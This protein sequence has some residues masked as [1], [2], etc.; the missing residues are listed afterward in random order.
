MVPNPEGAISNERNNLNQ[1]REKNKTKL[2]TFFQIVSL[3]FILQVWFSHHQILLH[4]PVLP[5]DQ[6]FEFDQN[7]TH[8]R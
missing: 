4:D 6:F 3:N 2:L 8:R 1:Q 5:C 7:Q